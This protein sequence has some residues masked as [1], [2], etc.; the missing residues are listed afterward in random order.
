MLLFLFFFTSILS[1][2]QKKIVRE[3]INSRRCQKCKENFEEKKNERNFEIIYRFN[4]VLK[5]KPSQTERQTI[6]TC[7]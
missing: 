3:L 6:E 2:A 1:A 5:A 4:N 7:S